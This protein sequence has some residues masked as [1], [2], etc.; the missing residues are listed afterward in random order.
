MVG[1][2]ALRR[3]RARLAESV[4][5]FRDATSLLRVTLFAVARRLRSPSRF[6]GSQIFS[7][8]GLPKRVYCA[9]SIFI[10][11]SSRQKMRTSDDRFAFAWRH[12]SSRYWTLTSGT[13]VL[14]VV[15]LILGSCATISGKLPASP[16]LYSG[17]AFRAGAA[18]VEIKVTD[19][20][21]LACA[22]KVFTVFGEEC[23]S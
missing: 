19:V 15:S 14:V 17:G 23:P 12:V 7:Q 10:S 16:T 2:Y 6:L 3:R 21:L 22:L 9:R 13:M 20:E 4:R 11:C 18:T 1:P 5:K 8:V